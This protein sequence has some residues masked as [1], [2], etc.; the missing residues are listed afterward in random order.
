MSTDFKLIPLK[1]IKPDPNQPRKYYDEAAMQ[2]LTDSVREKGILQP[3]LLRIK[4][5]VPGY[6]IVCGERRYKAA[7]AVQALH[8]DR[9]SI[10]AVIRE[11]SDEEAL[12]LQIIENLQR[13]DVH[14]LEE[15]VA[16]KSLLENKNRNLT[17]EEV[18]AKLGKTVYY[19]RQRY[20][21]NSLRK[22]WQDVFYKGK[23]DITTALAIALLAANEQE[24]LLKAKVDMK[25]LDKPDYF[26]NISEYDFNKLKRKLK[27]APFDIKDASLNPQ[28]GACGTCPFN[29]SVGA[30]FPEDAKDSICN[31]ATCFNLKCNKAFEIKLKAAVDDPAVILICGHV[32]NNE[33]KQLV[34]RMVKEGNKVYSTEYGGDCITSDSWQFKETR[35]AVIKGFYIGGNEKGRTINLKLK[36]TTSSNKTKEKKKAGKLTV[37]DVEG[38]ITRINERE[39]R[40]K[41]IDWQKIHLTTVAQ[42]KDN[43]ILE[44]PGKAIEKIDRG[45]MVYLLLEMGALLHDSIPGVPA[46]PNDSRHQYQEEYFEKLSKLSDAHL[47]LIIRMVAWGKYSGRQVPYGVNTED[48][49]LRMIASYAGVDLKKIEADQAAAAEKRVTNVTKKL[50]SLKKQKVELKKANGKKSAPKKKATKK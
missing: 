33:D 42:L 41:E 19:V 49:V 47:A 3:I 24:Q 48:T 25:R 44:K 10:A 14:P 5:G 12:E 8:K 35:G 50:E 11:L 16:I 36:T 38:E 28:L 30:L 29:S 22:G 2:E 23:L 6:F 21:L 1:D 17:I 27:D 18:A 40:S 43:P 31:N 20:K 26:P 46:H 45:I 34:D 13:K 4:M 32:Y 37:A 9:D 39:K 15:A 7:V